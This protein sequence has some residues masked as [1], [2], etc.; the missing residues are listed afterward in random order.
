MKIWILAS[1]D[2]YPF[3]FDVY[4]GRSPGESGPL[5]ERVVDK[6]TQCLEDKSLHTLYFDRFFSS[7]T[8][9]RKLADEGLR[10]TGTVQ[11]NRI[12]NSPLT[13][14]HEFKKQ[15]RGNYEYY[16]DNK[17]SVCQWVEWVTSGSRN[18]P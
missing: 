16:S 14:S 9:C 8:L 6:L 10:C 1:D 4:T 12:E 5:G 17:V 13:P 18:K 2:G 11:V 15:A 7:T 3:S